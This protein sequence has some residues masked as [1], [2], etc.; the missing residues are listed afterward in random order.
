MIVKMRRCYGRI[1]IIC[2]ALNGTE[3]MDIMIA[4]NNHQ[5][6]GM[7]PCGT[8]YTRTAVRQT[9]NFC[10]MGCNFSCIEILLYKAVGSFVRQCTNRTSL[11]YFTFAKQFFCVG[12]GSK[13]FPTDRIKAQDWAY[14]TEKCREALGFIESAR[15]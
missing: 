9:L 1:H 7:L 2:R 11:K 5:A 14:I 13:L 15:S 8:L 6:T 12:M 10:V 3:F 4:G